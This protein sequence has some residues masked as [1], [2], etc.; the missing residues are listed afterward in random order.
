MRQKLEQFRATAEQSNHLSRQQD[1]RMQSGL[2]KQGFREIL[3]V[4]QTGGAFWVSPFM[5][6][7]LGSPRWPA[8]CSSA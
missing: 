1:F 4:L 3:K 7:E 2:R 8:T 5:R 6:L